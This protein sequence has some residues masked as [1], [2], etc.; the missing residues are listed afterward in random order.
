MNILIVILGSNVLNLLND[1]IN[2]GINFASDERN[3]KYKNIKIDW[4]LSGGIKNPGES[5]ASEA[6]KMSEMIS[7]SV[8]F[9]YGVSKENWNYLLD[10][11]STN[12]AENFVMLKKMLEN[13]PNKYSEI[14]VVTSDFHFNRAEQ[15][16]NKIIENNKFNWLLSDMELHD[17]RY[18]ETIHIKNVDNDIKK[19][20]K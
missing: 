14:Y 12:T 3:F 18:W 13:N 6:F 2:L 19:S 20:I 15:F 10:E 1:R 9:T 5:T 7:T 11:T 4:F 8:D 17:S 16:A